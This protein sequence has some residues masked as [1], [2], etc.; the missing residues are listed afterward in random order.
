MSPLTKLL[1]MHS[2]I[3]TELAGEAVLE[4][5]ES[6]RVWKR[7]DKPQ[8]VVKIFS[9]Q[10]RR[11]KKEVLVMKVCLMNQEKEEIKHCLAKYREDKISL[12]KKLNDNSFDKS[13]AKPICDYIQ[14][15]D[16]VIAMLER[17]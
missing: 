16:N 12:R 1:L 7:P 8:S 5:G 11:F 15:I 9:N 4:I 14:I 2:V 6:K 3:M 13:L 10:I 17:V